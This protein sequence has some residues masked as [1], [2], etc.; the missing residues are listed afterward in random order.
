MTNLETIYLAADYVKA[1]LAGKKPEVG[2]VL[3]SGLGK[4]ADEIEEPL[5]IPYKDIPGFPVKASASCGSCSCSS[6]P[7][8]SS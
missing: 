7:P 4:L 6:S 1:R 8:Q 2:I 3:G 5:V